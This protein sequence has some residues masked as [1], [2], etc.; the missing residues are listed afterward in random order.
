MQAQIIINEIHPNPDSGSEWIELLLITEETDGSFS[1][2][3]FTIFD[4]ARQIYKFTNEQF[5][6]KLLVI[7]VSGLNNDTDSVILK[8]ELGNILDSFTYNQSEKGLSWSRE[9]IS[10]T[11][12]LTAPSRNLENLHITPTQT[13]TPTLTLT[14]TITFTPTPTPTLTPTTN[15]T[16]IN[17]LVTTTPQKEIRQLTSYDLS[18]IKLNSQDK[19]MPE[20]ELRLVFIGKQIGQA[21]IINAIIGSFL[22]ILSSIFLIYVKIKN[23]HH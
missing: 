6:N 2:T 16:P 15:P 14:A 1:L 8:N 9:N 3:N 4:S 17:N 18:K 19:E 13:P 10:N 12:I 23:K 22:I 21:E 5:I 7:E 11:F 20:R